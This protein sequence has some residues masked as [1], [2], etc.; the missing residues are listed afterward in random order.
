MKTAMLIAALGG[1]L[2][3]CSSPESTPV[4]RNATGPLMRSG[5]NCL[6]CHRTGGQAAR[7]VWTA[8]GTV[9]PRADSAVSEGVE[10][11]TVR[12]EDSTGK[13]VTLVTN[14]VGNFYTSEPLAKPLSMRVEYDGKERA[15]PIPLDA[16]GACNACHSSP[17]AIGGAAGRIRI[18]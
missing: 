4:D 13:R 16:E 18:P 12:I 8:A 17:D 2:A 3:A 9:Y 7:R 10:G 11:V 15:M 14:A 5:E 1:W 6:S